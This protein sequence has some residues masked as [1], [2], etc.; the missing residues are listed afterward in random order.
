MNTPLRRLSVAVMLLFGLLLL[1]ANYLQVVKASSLHENSHNPRLIAEE[2][3]RERGPIV[4]GGTQV[5]RS[6]ET[7]DRL[8]YLRQYSEPKLYAPATGF[9]SLVYGANGIEQAENSVLAGTDSALFVR[10]IIDLLTQTPPKG[11]SVALTL[12]PAAQRAAYDGLRK[13]PARGAVVA[14]DPTTGAIL[15]MVSTPSY[16]PNLISGHDTATVR[17]NYNRLSSQRSRPMLNRA[18]R[19]TYPPG[20]TFKLV[21][22]AA[23]LES[24]KYTPDSKV[25]NSSVLKLPQTSATLP[26][27][28]G[29]PCTSGEA[30]L[31]VALE[32]SCN[33]A[34]G[35]VGL[36]LGADA[37]Q[38]QARKFGFGNAY[39]VP[40]RSVAS[41]FPE[42]INE[43]QTAQSAIGQFD[44]RAT[45]LQMAM[46]AAA[47]ANRGV[48]MSPYLVQ[49]VRGP[50]LEVLDSTKP[51]SLGQAVSP[52][53]AAALTTMMTK[54]V[55]EGTGTNGQIPGVPV[56]GK[57]GTAQQGEGRTPHAWFVSFAPADAEPKVAVAVIVE[58][59][60]DQPEISGNGLAAPIAQAVMRAVLKK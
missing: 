51:Q 43:P 45:P 41:H 26:N 18:L 46:V 36:D 32:N 59:G 17:E 52:Q 3:S 58:D 55:D 6:V 37:L 44:V 34:F 9:Y 33:V 49:E 12:D 10:R 42:N 2:Y 56:A 19:E 11:G 38:E 16:D 8:K 50:K 24:G 40:M 13:I 53:T 48:V 4:V 1:N 7:D 31:T 47:I 54:V 21:T 5:A 35:A 25:D 57:T 60:A 14:L 23:A 15:A 39:E 30:T 20:S 22:A 27:E 28:N 29:G